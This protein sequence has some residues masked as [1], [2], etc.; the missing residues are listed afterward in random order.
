MAWVQRNLAVLCLVLAGDANAHSWY[1]SRTDPVL[2]LKCCGDHDC[3]PVDSSYVRSTLEGYYVRQPRPYSRNDPQP[4]SGLSQGTAFRL[5][6]MTSIIFAKRCIQPSELA[7]T[8]CGGPASLRRVGP[9]QFQ[10]EIRPSA[11]FIAF[12]G[13]L[14]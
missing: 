14:Q 13:C 5:R 10:T 1:T 2:H 8:R 7:D 4:E 6:R 11:T 12:C 9:V 3:H